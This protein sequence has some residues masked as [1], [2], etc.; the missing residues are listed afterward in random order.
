MPTVTDPASR[1]RSMIDSSTAAGRDFA[2]GLAE[3]TDA[4]IAELHNAA[5]EAHPRVPKTALLA[6]GGYGRGELAPFSD[7]D[8]LL[9]HRSKSERIEP[10]ASAI[11][12]PIWDAGCILGHSV[13]SVDE[14]VELAKDDLDTATALLTA[15]HIAGD[16]RLAA[17]VIEHGRSLWRRRRKRYFAELRDRVRARQ[18]EAGDVAYMLEPDLKDGHGGLRDVHSLWWAQAGGLAIRPDDLEALDEC[19]AT[20]MRVRVGLHRST[21][22]RGEVLRLEDQDAAASSAGYGD[23]DEMMADIAAAS[24]TIA[25]IADEN[26][27]RF[28]RIGDGRPTVVAPGIDLVEG[29]IELAEGADPEGDPTLILR[30]AQAAARSGARIGRRSLDRLTAEMPEWPETWPAGAVDDLVALLLEA[31]AA[32]PVLESLDQRA[33]IEKILPE[34]RPV[35][36]RP[37]RNAYHRFTVDRHLW[38][39]AANVA[40]LAGR[41]QRPDLL[42]LGAL[43]HDIGKGYQGDHTVVGMELV[44]ERIGPRLGLSESDIDVLVAMVEHHLLLPDVAMRRDLSDPSTIAQVA[45]VVGDP[46][47]LELLHA[48]TEGDSKATGP[49]AWGSW[50][51]GLVNDLVKRVQHVLGGG[52]V[53]EAT[54]R[55][56][57]DAETLERMASGETS[58]VTDDDRVTVVTPDVPGAFSR[59]AGV[60]SLHGLDVASAQAHSDEPQ[61][62]RPAMAASQFL[63]I[64]PRDGID[65]SPVTADLDRALHGQLAIE[66]RLAE[67]ARTYRRRRATQA[68]L[69]PEPRVVFHDGASSNATVIEVH[70]VSKVGVLHRITK[71]LAELD[72]D[73]R[74][75]T[76]QTI[77]MEVVDT[78]YVRTRS[79]TLLTDRFH[80]DEVRRAVLHVVG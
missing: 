33:L 48:L 32:I 36:S 78:F 53:T 11:W 47:R 52:E 25:W 49:S 8:L 40:T 9:V 28:G 71:A 50:K 30:V 54:W 34:W 66:S 16:T 42:V 74:H 12:Y 13:R 51:E 14:Q 58:V 63:V 38:E 80:R 72:L 35:R 75:A 22:R 29:E 68:Q 1:R 61:P 64:R 17:E 27:G 59:V 31:H 45:A 60:L 43:F 23:A 41:V 56:F 3:V 79:G 62:G 21:G 6:I 77:G 73:I 7:L 19:Y 55:L 44:R 26:W 15:R 46:V 2:V 65:W 67:R 39:A 76:V 37:Q 5:R 20:L 69:P 57:P 18:A 4:W 70:C 10:V 24:R